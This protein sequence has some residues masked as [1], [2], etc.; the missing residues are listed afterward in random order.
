MSS[1]NRTL[2][3]AIAGMITGPASPADAATYTVPSPDTPTIAS[4]LVLA[5]ATTDTVDILPGTY[6]ESGLVLRGSITVR[7]VAGAKNT[8]IDAGGQGS[9]FSFAGVYR[10]TLEGLTITGG[11]AAKGAAVSATTVGATIRNCVIADNHATLEGGGLAG[12]EIATWP[13]TIENTRFTGNTAPLGGALQADHG[14]YVITGCVFDG[15]AASQGGA[16]NFYFASLLVEGCLFVDNSAEEGAGIDGFGAVGPV[17]VRGCTFHGNS[18]PAGTI[19]TFDGGTI[20]RTI[21]AYSDGPAC[22]GGPLRTYSCCDLFGNAGGN[23]I[24]GVDGGGNFA[25][26]PLFCDAAGGD[27]R[28]HE[29]SPCLPGHHP[30]SAD[31]GVIGALE[32][33]CGAATSAGEGLQAQ[34]WSLVKQGYR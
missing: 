10:G 25:L 24:C 20:E 29:D 4:A 17:V 12:S 18:S 15:N 16:V 27:F 8:I 9:V 26:D 28:L 19:A 34:S 32:A 14:D 30:G 21:I 31:C 13:F 1:M 33:G 2:L 5:T 3:F 11:V 6:L 7:G 22:S 23:A